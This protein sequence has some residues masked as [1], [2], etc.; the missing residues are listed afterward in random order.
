MARPPTNHEATR[1]RL[2]S[3]AT[4]A[5]IERGASR[6]QV[7]EVAQAAG[8]TAPAVYRYFRDRD[9]LLRAALRRQVEEFA[10]EVTD[11]SRRSATREQRTAAFLEDQAAYL[12]RTDVGAV[13]F[14]LECVLASAD[15]P[16]LAAEVVPATEALRGLHG[17]D[18]APDDGGDD[19]LRSARLV[20]ATCAGI[21]FLHAAGLLEV[22]PRDLYGRLLELLGPD[23]GEDR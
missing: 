21:Q 20:A 4:E 22:P 14:L 7:A 1:D 5:V 19:A 13:R 16:G 10:R 3:L 6:V 12:E 18:D 23:G 11:A 2:L 15:D 17:G 9:D 8:L